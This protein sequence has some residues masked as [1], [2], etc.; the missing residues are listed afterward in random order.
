MAICA[1][2]EK[3]SMLYFVPEWS[4]YHIMNKIIIIHHV[5][6]YVYISPFVMVFTDCRF[7]SWRSSHFCLPPFHLRTLGRTSWRNK[8]RKEAFLFFFLLKKSI[9]THC[10]SFLENVII[11]LLSLSLS[12][13][14]C[15]NGRKC[16]IYIF[17]CLYIIHIKTFITCF[18]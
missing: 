5:Y 6:I 12:H 1:L 13:T 10:F 17:I 9:V 16:Y 11:V 18:M 4:M 7:W 8:R 3:S 2:D 14:K 15:D